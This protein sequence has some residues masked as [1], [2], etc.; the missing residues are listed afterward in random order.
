MIILCWK[1]QRETENPPLF[2][3]IYGEMFMRLN[4]KEEQRRMLVFQ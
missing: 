1:I 2:G 3:N 4:R